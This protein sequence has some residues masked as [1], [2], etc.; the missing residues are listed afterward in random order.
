M[1]YTLVEFAQ[2]GVGLAVKAGAEGAELVTVAEIV[3]VAA[4]LHELVAVTVS[5]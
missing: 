2:T 5:V 3:A 4:V 1:V